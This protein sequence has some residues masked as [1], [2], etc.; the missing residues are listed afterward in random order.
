LLAFQLNYLNYQKS[1]RV[2]YVHNDLI[3]RKIMVAQTVLQ[4][5]ASS[6]LNR[7]QLIKL[8]FK[9]M[10]AGVWF[11]ALPMIDRVLVDLT[12]KVTENIRSISLAKS[13]LTVVGKLEGLLESSVLKSLRSV[14]R[15]LAEK[16]SL[17][18][19]KWGNVSAK[20]WATDSSFAFFLAVMHTNR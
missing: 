15:Q 6:F 8:K 2:N 9:A 18:A 4:N 7:T 14:G 20:N 1:F 3:E 12:I 5:S 19:Q 17:I 16:L 13:I 11:K 10:R